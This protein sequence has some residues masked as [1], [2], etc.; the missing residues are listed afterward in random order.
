MMKI[1]GLEK[2]DSMIEKVKEKIK[3]LSK[4]NKKLLTYCVIGVFVLITIIGGSY[5]ILSLTLT[6]RKEL[7]IVAGTLA[8]RYADGNIVSLENM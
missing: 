4:D 5:A 8:V 2:S 3:D 7:E 1:D 6:G